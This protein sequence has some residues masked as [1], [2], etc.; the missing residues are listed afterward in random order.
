MEKTW[1]GRSFFSV[2][3]HDEYKKDN[4]NQKTKEKFY[5]SG[6]EEAKGIVATLARNDFYGIQSVHRGGTDIL[7]E[8]R[9]VE[10]GCGCGR[11]TKSLAKIFK[12]VTAVDI[13]DG[14]LKIAREE[15]PDFNIDFRL[16]KSMH[17][18]EEIPKADVVYSRIVLQHNCPPVI[19]YLLDSMFHVLKNHGMIF[20]QVPTY[21]DGYGWEYTKYME[22][23]EHM[24]MHAFPQLKIFE[25]AQKNSCVPCEVFQDGWT[26]NWGI[27]TSFVFRKHELENI[28][29]QDG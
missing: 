5:E 8:K 15:V 16:I 10:Y 22:E 11:V 28:A 6:R 12:H 3:T 23:I 9:V 26:G 2:L 17:D 13:S 4:I 29:C 7:S 19:E 20:F 25:L 24:E 14:N 27:S 1:P 21:Q 18:Y